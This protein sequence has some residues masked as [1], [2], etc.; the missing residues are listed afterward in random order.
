MFSKRFNSREVNQFG[1]RVVRFYVDLP[2]GFSLANHGGLVK[3]TSEYGRIFSMGF[4]VCPTESLP[5]YIPD[6][7]QPSITIAHV[8]VN[9]HWWGYGN[10]SSSHNSLE[11]APSLAS[12][13]PAETLAAIFQFCETIAEITLPKFVS[14]IEE[15]FWHEWQ[16]AGFDAFLPLVCQYEVPETRYRL[17]FAVPELK[18]AV[19]LDGYEWH[20][21]KAQFTKDRSRQRELESLGWRFVRF[22]GSEIYKDAAERVNE[23]AAVFCDFLTHYPEASI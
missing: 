4:D 18:F 20:S 21:S 15:S 22:S 7:Y 11:T 6:E 17:D 12:Q 14:P 1:S 2:G 5:D 19:E 9:R 13:V 3:Q 23:A 10:F 16:Q 8:I